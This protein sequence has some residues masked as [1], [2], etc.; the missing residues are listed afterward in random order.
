MVFWTAFEAMAGGSGAEPGLPKAFQEERSTA[1]RLEASAHSSSLSGV[2]GVFTG[3]SLC[4]SHIL[5]ISKRRYR[6]F[7]MSAPQH[8]V[9]TLEESGM[10]VVLEDSSSTNEYNSKHPRALMR[11]ELDEE[12]VR[13]R[14]VLHI[15]WLQGRQPTCDRQKA[16]FRCN[17]FCHAKTCASTCTI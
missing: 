12:Q 16:A 6:C 8:L 17:W 15:Q 10:P 3:P 1:L 13:A 7:V 5:T 14:V 11:Q 9:R 2:E 4:C